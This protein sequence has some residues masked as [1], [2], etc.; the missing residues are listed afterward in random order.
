[1]ESRY[2]WSALLSFMVG[3]LTKSRSNRYIETFAKSR[4]N[5]KNF[6]VE[7]AAGS[8]WLEF[9]PSLTMVPWLMNGCNDREVSYLHCLNASAGLP[10]PNYCLSF[11]GDLNNGLTSCSGP[12]KKKKHAVPLGLDSTSKYYPIKSRTSLS[13][14]ICCPIDQIQQTRASPKEEAGYRCLRVIAPK[15]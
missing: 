11:F 6:K 10:C 12:K 8:G 13:V 7:K 5:G 15:S 3:A 14:Y 9:G 2:A 4:T 1:M